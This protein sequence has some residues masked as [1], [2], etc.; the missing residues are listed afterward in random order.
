[1]CRVAAFGFDRLFVASG[2]ERWA[3]AAPSAGAE[4]SQRAV[5]PHGNACDQGG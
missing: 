1:M 4:R 2:V 3:A 5:G